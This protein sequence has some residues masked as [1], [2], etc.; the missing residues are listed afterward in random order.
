MAKLE[1]PRGFET[2][3]DCILSKMA[4]GQ[5]EAG[6]GR[7]VSAED[8]FAA[9][10]AELDELRAELAEA[11][12]EHSEILAGPID[13]PQ[14]EL[15]GEWETGLFCGLEDQNLQS[16]PYGA[17]R[18]GFEAGVERMLE[19]AQGIIRAYENDSPAPKA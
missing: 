9:A 6:S 14:L 16:D 8:A 15:A 3:L 17:C 19:W 18:Y 13:E 7:Y 2:W 4:T 12:G 1:P 5:C 10:R 11:K